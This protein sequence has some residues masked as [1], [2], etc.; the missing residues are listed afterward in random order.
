[1]NRYQTM[2]EQL[3]VPAGQAERLKDAVLA[4]KPEKQRRAYRPRSF[5]KKAL[6]AAVLTAALTVSVS[7]A[8]HSVD[9]DDIFTE[10]FGTEAA[11]TP[12]AGQI[13]QEINASAVCDD[14]TLTVRQAVG[15]EKMLYLLYDYQLPESADLA[16]LETAWE[17]KEIYMSTATLLCGEELAWEDV[18]D[19]DEQQRWELWERGRKAW[20]GSR[21]VRTLRFDP[22]RR[23]L[24]FLLIYCL[25]EALSPE[26]PITL[27]VGT[28]ERDGQPWDPS[29]LTAYTAAVTFRNTNT[30]QSRSG[31]AASRSMEYTVRVSPLIVEVETYGHGTTPTME[32]MRE[33][34]SLRYDDGTD[35]KLTE[36]TELYGI[37][38]DITFEYVGEAY[39]KKLMVRSDTWAPLTEMIDPS[40]VEAVLIGDLEI[41]L[42]S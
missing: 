6:L 5:G 4:A 11:S 31:E 23:T 15:D 36:I 41:P 9:W 38:W 28:P 40:R 7:A 30:A 34:I 14:V 25:E 24:S 2:M 26:E 39:R 27:L 29:V 42:I 37:D 33:L 19:M 12:I 18:K 1:M 16:A 22:E 35:V 3:P 17:T 21:E 13:F 20:Y 8:V 10:L 32:K